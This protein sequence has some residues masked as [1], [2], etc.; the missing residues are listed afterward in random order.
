[1]DK[2]VDIGA[3]SAMYGGSTGSLLLWGLQ[4]NDLAAIVAALVAVAGL[5]VNVWYT[6]QKNSRAQELHR[7]NLE[8]L[9]DKTDGRR[10]SE[11]EEGSG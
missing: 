3:Q 1:M 8:G 4:I 7:A 9:R 6:L 10:L 2:T 5:V 11:P